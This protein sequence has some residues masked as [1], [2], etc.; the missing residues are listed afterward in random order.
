[1]QGTAVV[2]SDVPA[3]REVAG[4]AARLV[5]AAAPDEWVTALGDLL[6]HPERR[7]VLEAA[8]RQRAGAFSWERCV[9]ATRAVYEEALG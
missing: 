4:G 6:S 5:E 8:G 9:A 2:C 7:A 3:L 1:M